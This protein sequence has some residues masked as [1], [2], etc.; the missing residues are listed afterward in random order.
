MDWNNNL[1]LL[2]PLFL[3]GATLLLAIMAVVAWRRRPGIGATP[4]AFYMVASGLWCFGYGMEIMATKLDSMLFWSKVQYLGISTV[5]VFCLIFCLQ[6]ARRWRLPS[7]FFSLLFIIPIFTIIV[8]WLEPY[9]GLL[10]QTIS[11]DALGS[12]SVLTFTYGPV[13]WLIIAYSY[14]A[15]ITS[16]FIL[17]DFSRR[18]PEIYRK[19]IQLLVMASL[20]PWLGNIFYVLKISFIPNL[21]LTPNDNDIQPDSL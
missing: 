4:F 17:V 2:I 5:A 18:V 6:Y 7:Y 15:L 13:F 16:T 1:F 8:A 10:W 12:F 14:I 21:D 9:T 20:L 19:Q 3:F 11:V